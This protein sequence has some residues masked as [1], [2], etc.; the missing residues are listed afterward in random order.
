MQLFW[1]CCRFWWPRTVKAPPI[2]HHHPSGWKSRYLLSFWL[3][4]PSDKKCKQY[5]EKLVEGLV[6]SPPAA[7]AKS[8]TWYCYSESIEN[9]EDPGMTK[10]IYL[11]PFHYSSP[12]IRVKEFVSSPHLSSFSIIQRTRINIFHSSLTIQAGVMSGVISPLTF[13]SAS[14]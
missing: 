1:Q 10:L 6:P 7:K 4:S 9:L 8:L 2:L 3:P 12:F 13:F 14:K 11:C 5:T